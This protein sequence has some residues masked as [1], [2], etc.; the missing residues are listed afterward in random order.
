MWGSHEEAASSAQAGKCTEFCLLTDFASKKRAVSQ[1]QDIMLS[2][3][4][5]CGNVSLY[6]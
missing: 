3:W 4:F 6:Y 2:F 5:K 1:Q